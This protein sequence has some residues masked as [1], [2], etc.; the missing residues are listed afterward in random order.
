M[1][2]KMTDLEKYEMLSHAHIDL[3]EVREY[4][5][6]KVLELLSSSNSKLGC[7]MIRKCFNSICDGYISE[8]LENFTDAR[9][10]YENLGETSDSNFVYALMAS[11]KESN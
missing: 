7:L 5:K 8:H 6:P 3:K 9:I 2:D 10:V 4:I 11:R 1:T